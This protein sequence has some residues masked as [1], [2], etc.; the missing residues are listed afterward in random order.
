MSALPYLGEEW[1]NQNQT[2]WLLDFSEAWFENVLFSSLVTES[3]PGSPVAAIPIRQNYLHVMGASTQWRLLAGGQKAFKLGLSFTAWDATFL[4]RGSA[5]EF[6]A[7]GTAIQKDQFC[8]NTAVH[9]L[10]HHFWLNACATGTGGHDTRLAWCDAAGSCGPGA[11]VVQQCVMD[12]STS[13]DDRWDSVHR[14][15][16]DDLFSGDP[17]C[18]SPPP[19]PKETTI[20]TQVNPY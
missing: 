4:F 1:F 18:G 7:G 19:D 3:P 20:R 2:P 11:L 14:F 12:M 8:Q 9:E 10:G 17:T 13:L 5:E 15:C 6:A 16:V